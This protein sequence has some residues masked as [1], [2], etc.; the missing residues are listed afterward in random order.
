MRWL[1]ND[2]RPVLLVALMALAGSWAGG[3]RAPA[4]GSSDAGAGVESEPAEPPPP[5]EIPYDGR[6]RLVS[7]RAEIGETSIDLDADEILEIPGG[8]SLY[9]ETWP[10]LEDHRVRLVTPND[11]LVPFSL[12]TGPVAVRERGGHIEPGGTWVRLI[13]GEALREGTEYQLRIEP[14]LGERI[15][16]VLD[17][18]Y[19][20]L[21]LPL[22]RVDPDD[23][24]DEA[25]EDGALS[26]PAEAAPGAQ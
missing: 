20:D 21:I 18:P 26:P 6:L 25:P 13:P 2:P 9:L 5:P 1:P 14:E 24:A 19:E 17:R 12:E 22:R 3:C 4:P 16:D 23:E 10:R 7:V 15:T 11:R 8:A